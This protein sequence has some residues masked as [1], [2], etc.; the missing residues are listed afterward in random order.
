MVKLTSFLILIHLFLSCTKE[1]EVDLPTFE[2]RLNIE[3]RISVGEFPV[4]FVSRNLNIYES[5]SLDNYIN[6]FVYDA[7]VYFKID[8]DSVL[9]QP[10]LISDLNQ[11]SLFSVSEIFEIEPNEAVLL[12]IKVY[13]TS[14]SLFKG[15]VNKLH[16]ISIKSED[17]LVTGSTFLPDPVALDNLYWLPLEENNQYGSSV[18]RLSDP[19]GEFNAYRWDVKRINLKNGQDKDLV[20]KSPRSGFFSDEVIDGLTIEFDYPNPMKRK[21][22]THLK[23]YRRYYRYKD[24]VVVKFSTMDQQVYEFY[25]S[26]RAQQSSSANPFSTPINVR[27]NLDGPAVGIWAGFSPSFDTLICVP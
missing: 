14:D 9:L 3:G 5:T 2:D 18:A 25:R 24:T 19:S 1:V 11:N 22:S 20:F 15:Q 21:D 26:K 7:E 17:K 16:E 8:Q 12:P 10:I 13:T 6:S 4:I 23:Q 27:T